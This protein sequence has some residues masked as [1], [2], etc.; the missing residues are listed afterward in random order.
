MS[1][2]DGPTDN[3][4]LHMTDITLNSAVA[5]FGAN[6]LNELNINMRGA[7]HDHRLIA[8]GQLGGVRLW[9]STPR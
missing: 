8:I 2:P 9:I 3:T 1:L 5:N 6:P 4:A 7:H